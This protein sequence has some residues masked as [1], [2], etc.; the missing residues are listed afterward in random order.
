MP[1]I[2]IGSGL[3]TLAMFTEQATRTNRF[4]FERRIKLIN[5]A[6]HRLEKD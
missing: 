4:Y 2:A 3:H 1:T 6:L 5:K